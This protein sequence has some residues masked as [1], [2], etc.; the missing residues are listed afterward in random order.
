MDTKLD[1]TKEELGRKLYRDLIEDPFPI[2][3]VEP[4][5]L[6]SAQG[7]AD[8]LNWVRGE[9]KDKKRIKE[10]EEHIRVCGRCCEAAWDLIEIALQEQR[11]SERYG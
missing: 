1:L 3:K 6:D 7:A 2:E 8:L 10:I 5:L 11:D 9:L 4:C